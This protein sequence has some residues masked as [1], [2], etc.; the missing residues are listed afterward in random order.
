MWPTG[1][2]T[3]RQQPGRVIARNVTGLRP[4]RGH[5]GRISWERGLQQRIADP[6][7]GLLA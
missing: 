3:L 5:T 6:G 4:D 2:S 7:A 1:K